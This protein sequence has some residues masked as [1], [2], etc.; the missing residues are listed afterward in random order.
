MITATHTHAG[1]AHYFESEAYGGATSSRLPGFDEAVLDLLA[2][3]IAAGIEHA[4]RSIKP[5]A[6]RWVHDSNAWGLTRNRSL[7]PFL[8]NT[9]LFVPPSA[10]P[11]ELPADERA[12]DPELDVLQIEELDRKSGDHKGP[13][14]WLVF[15]AMHPTVLPASNRLT[16]ADLFGATS[17]ILEER[18]RA[19]HAATEP[20][21]IPAQAG[22]ICPELSDIDPLAAIVNTNE[23]DV[24]PIWVTGTTDEAM[25]VGERLAERAWASHLSTAPFHDRVLLD[26]RYLESDLA[27]TPLLREG[28]LCPKGELGAAAGHGGSDHPTSVDGILPSAGDRDLKRTDCQAPKA[29]LLGLIQPFLVG[30]R[31]DRYPEHVSFALAHLDD[32]WIS[33]VPAELTVHSGWAVDRRVRAVVGPEAGP[34]D[35]FVVAGLANAYIQYV[36]TSREYQFQH[37]EGGSTLYGP[38]TAEFFAERLE[39]LARSMRGENADAYL[40][41][42][43]PRID[44]AVQ[45]EFSFA[46]ARHRLASPSEGP[47]LAEVSG[48]GPIRFCRV[49]EIADP[50]AV[51]FYWKDGAPGRVTLSNAKGDPWL[52]LV[53]A[54]ASAPVHTWSREPSG[55]IFHDPHAFIDDRGLDFQTRVLGRDGN[56]FI[57]STLFRPSLVEWESLKSMGK[58][59][60][61]V[62][63]DA[64]SA[65]VLS[66]A[67]SASDPPLDCPDTI[68]LEC[69]GKSE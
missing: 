12:I 27:G 2:G 60:L 46:P 10:P 34:N 16:G 52:E 22:A 21:C 50:P 40:P 63:G 11:P 17:R 59:R 29:E 56:G 67:F 48:R 6:L 8:S 33:F 23:G 51:C 32:T 14:G 43:Q 35:H 45:T 15:Y 31:P 3:R 1:P 30:L 62:R 44:T 41:P 39:L 20:R 49:R 38:R 37:Y 68:V 4:R 58:V 18:L 36:A 28:K 57:W 53:D 61:R 13:L 26:T 64:A 19:T 5:A 69:L 65:P 25:A 55:T 47:P 9:P 42:R 24:S 54:T 7:V 66:N